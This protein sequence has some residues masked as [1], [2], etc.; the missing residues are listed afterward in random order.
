[1]NTEKLKELLAAA[2]PGPW[3]VCQDPPP[4]PYWQPGFTVGAAD[5][6]DA[7]RVCDTSLLDWRLG[8]ANAALIVAAVNALPSLIAR[9]EAADGLVATW[10]EHAALYECEHEPD[11]AGT[12][13][14]CAD[15]L[16]AALTTY[17]QE[18]AREHG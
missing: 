6:K 17:D 15:D 10:R 16:E 9:L 12:L 2:T 13:V 18:K 5:P 4:N 11:I 1:M 7:R 14:R 3:A 8:L